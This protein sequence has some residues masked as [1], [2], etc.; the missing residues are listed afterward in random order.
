MRVGCS[1]KDRDNPAMRNLHQAAELSGA[2]L[3]SRISVCDSAGD[4]TAGTTTDRPRISCELFG[5]ATPGKRGEVY[6][7]QHIEPL[8]AARTPRRRTLPTTCRGFNLSNDGI[9]CTPDGDHCETERIAV[10]P[11]LLCRTNEEIKQ[12]WCH[13]KPPDRINF[14]CILST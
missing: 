11:V 13:E 1:T 6:S 10:I 3:N 5:K 2:P 8:C 14:L 9:S 7:A 12:K 4:V